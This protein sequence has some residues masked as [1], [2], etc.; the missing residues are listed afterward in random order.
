MTKFEER[1][2]FQISEV[3]QFYKFSV[4]C[5]SVSNVWKLLSLC[6]RSVKVM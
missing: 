1:N 4:Y 3:L 2:I 6:N 5:F